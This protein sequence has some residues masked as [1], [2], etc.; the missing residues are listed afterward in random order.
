MYRLIPLIQS[1]KCDLVQSFVIQFGEF[2]S[3]RKHYRQQVPLST[4]LYEPH[5]TTS[6]R[7]LHAPKKFQHHIFLFTSEI[8]LFSSHYFQCSS[9]NIMQSQTNYTIYLHTQA[10]IFNS[11]T[12]EYKQ[13]VWKCS[14]PRIKMLTAFSVII[15]MHTPYYTT[16]Y[17]SISFKTLEYTANL[18]KCMFLITYFLGRFFGKY[19]TMRGKSHHKLTQP[20]THLQ[21]NTHMHWKIYKSIIKL[22]KTR[23]ES[24]RFLH[25][26]KQENKNTHNTKLAWWANG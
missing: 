2:S 8:V 5:Y 25:D 9:G 16:R 11:Y 26:Q 13:N 18:S 6:H 12:L 14:V 17:S 20:A 1:L 19:S 7:F 21:H 22:H 4:F 3:V 23:R 10:L 24:V 15:I